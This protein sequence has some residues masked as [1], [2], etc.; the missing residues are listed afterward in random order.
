MA[1]L[2]NDLTQF[3]R[4]LTRV[5]TTTYYKQTTF[6]L[7]REQSE[8]YS[9]LMT[10]LVAAV[11]LAHDPSTGLPAE[12]MAEL[13]ARAQVAWNKVVGLM[14][15]FDL[16]PNRVLDVILDI[17]ANHV[18]N[19]YS[20][21]LE[22]LRLSSWAPS[23]IE[24][25]YDKS[26][27]VVSAGSY[28]GMKF[29]DVLMIAELG[30][31]VPD[32]PRPTSSSVLAQILGFKY[33]QNV[34]MD[35]SRL[36]TLKLHAVAALLIREG[37]IHLEELYPHLSPLDEEMGKAEEQYQQNMKQKA[38]AAQ[39]S[40]GPSMGDSPLK[41]S[42]ASSRSRTS[43]SLDGAK[44]G[45]PN[46]PK[47][48]P[49]QKYRLL[50]FLLCL[51]ALRPA[52]YL[53]AQFPWLPCAH[54]ELSDI[55]LYMV[56]WSI[57][58]LHQPFSKAAERITAKNHPITDR[59]I[60]ENGSPPKII[61]K[62]KAL[63]STYPVPQ[64]NQYT[65]FVFFYPASQNHIP[66]CSNVRELFTVA[67]PLLRYVKVN[68]CR[69]IGLLTH[70]CRIG[71]ADLIEG[72]SFGDD[73]F[74]SRLSEWRGMLRLYIL[75]A[76]S[77]TRAN[78]AFNVEVWN[79][80]KFYDQ[81]ER[82][83]MYGE[84][85][86][87]HA[88]YPEVK[89]RHVEV[90]R[91]VRS[92]LRRVTA[93]ST[94][95]LSLPLAK[96]AHSNPCLVFAESVRQSMAYDN[97]IE[98]I[99]ESARS[100]TYLGYDVLVYS[101]L[102]AFTNS[103][104]PRMKEDGTSVAM[105]LQSLSTYTATL[106]KKF[107]GSMDS[108][109]ILQLLAHRLK[110][111][112]SADLIILKELIAKTTQIQPQANLTDDQ[113]AC[114]GGGSTLHPNKNGI[115][116]LSGALQRTDLTVALLVLIAQQREF[117]IETVDKS[118]EHL[119]HISNLYDECQAILFQYVEFL[120]SAY[121]TDYASLLP[122]LHELC[123]TYKLQPDI[124]FHIWRPALHDP[125]LTHNI[126][127]IRA[128]EEKRIQKA[129]EDSE[130]AERRLKQELA[131]KR[132]QSQATAS[133]SPSASPLP[134]EGME[135][136]S[137]DSKQENMPPFESVTS[138]EVD[139]PT[140]K[141][142]SNATLGLS[143]NGNVD[144][145][146]TWLPQLVPIMESAERVLPASA[147]RVFSPGLYVTFWQMSMYDLVPLQKP[148]EREVSKINSYLKSMPS[149]DRD[150]RTEEHMQATRKALLEEFTEQI[151]N[152]QA[153]QERLNREKN[154]WFNPDATAQEAVRHFTQHC[155]H[156][157]SLLSPTDAEF[158]ARFLKQLHL[159][160]TPR[161]SSLSAYNNA[162]DLF[163]QHL[164]NQIFCL[165]EHEIYNF[166]RF[167]RIVL[168][169]LDAFSTDE[170]SFKGG[171][172]NLQARAL[173][174]FAKKFSPAEEVTYA[175]LI[176]IAEFTGLVGKFIMRLRKSIIQLLS[177]DTY[178]GVRNAVI[179]LNGISSVFPKTTSQGNAIKAVI[180][181]LVGSEK[182]PDLQVLLKSYNTLLQT[183]KSSW[184]SDVAGNGN[185]NAE[186]PP[187]RSASPV[188]ANL[189]S[190]PADVIM[191][192]P[193]SLSNALVAQAT[194]PK[195]PI[196]SI[197]RPAVVRRVRG[198]AASSEISR[199][200]T[201]ESLPAKPSAM[202]QEGLKPA[203]SASLPKT[204]QVVV[205]PP[206]R[207]R[208]DSANPIPGLPPRPQSQED[209]NARKQD[210]PPPVAPSSTSAAQ[211]IRVNT[212]HPADPILDTAPPRPLTSD[213]VK[214]KELS[215][216]RPRTPTEPS[217][218]RRQSPSSNSR[219]RAPSVESHSSARDDRP[220]ADRDRDRERSDR[221][222]GGSKDE[223]K[224][225]PRVGRLE[226]D[227]RSRDR[228]GR[229]R[230]RDRDAHRD[231]DSGRDRGTREKDI[232]DARDRDR[233][234]REKE[235][236]KRDRDRERDRDNKDSDR[237][238]DRPRDKDRSSRRDGAPEPGPRRMM[239]ANGAGGAILS[240]SSRRDSKNE[241]LTDRER[242][243]DDS[244]H[245]R[246][247]GDEDDSQSAKRIRGSD[248]SR[249]AASE[250]DRDRDRENG[251]DRYRDD[252][253]RR[254][255]DTRDTRD[256]NRRD[257]TRRS[258]KDREEGGSTPPKKISEDNMTSGPPPT[259]PRANRT[260]D[261]P[262]DIG[263]TTR[264]P[265]SSG[266]RQ[267]ATS[268][269]LAD[270]LSVAPNDSSA[271]KDDGKG[272]SPAEGNS[273]ANGAEAA[274]DVAQPPDYTPSSRS[275]VPRGDSAGPSNNKKRTSSHIS[276][277]HEATAGAK[278]FAAANAAAGSGSGSNGGGAT[279]RVKIDRTRRSGPK[280]D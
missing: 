2:V 134:G 31:N 183:R 125:I 269:R 59:I 188:T 243:G 148:T 255:R 93:N 144:E 171:G 193:P 182:R 89:V 201:P 175:E 122:S 64:S 222:R 221:D 9:K 49:N 245:K 163:G 140:T 146:P 101:V 95:K 216:P 219:S 47:E 90:T 251:R 8:G 20:F 119:K 208:P 147:L 69:D 73:A 30:P 235:D 256:D 56:R 261:S 66:V 170:K 116:R 244:S 124:A 279:K 237:E 15:V 164:A 200:G 121:G 123:T 190:R 113:V 94:N 136:I 206:A 75:P 156:P 32:P 33:V 107:G 131:A 62:K 241:D 223:I 57:A 217:K 239:D 112:R 176:T 234:G 202:L 247:R 198:E 61:P 6:N 40:G 63:T 262:R 272:K 78:A 3:E 266:T 22:L 133:P 102:T 132:A 45:S 1:G 240:R 28:E 169:D 128:F 212:G 108:G 4:K 185:S 58:P 275:P 70:I 181:P 186:P 194:D 210:M 215:T 265:S 268:S 18:L 172:K 127:F 91:E 72:K 130:A 230:D 195:D 259:A 258:R 154:H 155:L 280:M 103:A 11:G 16:N 139:S 143:N 109:P 179:F 273:A 161:F 48:P 98:A 191:L 82:W 254:D 242:R 129:K 80:L 138:M 204:P 196:A 257:S 42:A 159:I 250:K 189:P 184:I 60:V 248:G 51:G 233:R 249:Y 226:D 135:I 77:M 106:Y 173:P 180:E 104:K 271:P 14:G 214:D 88:L 137:K 151:D 197:P 228:S 141:Q 111:F 264:A 87:S 174:G 41:S 192:E 35:A 85:A 92:I 231:R 96:L 232:R 24:S 270:R 39:S 276:A 68:A 238:W 267:L 142:E 162:S 253:S 46:I 81:T 274:K 105:W 99:A 27:T 21:F 54:T 263:D 205:S 71:K 7:L 167:Y 114:M 25:Q 278:L 203:P 149:R 38:I 207:R 225:R 12:S 36:D 213:L 227:D 153:T 152:R 43:A 65:E 83:G 55:I 53:L 19:H 177:S 168:E 34:T 158:S 115:R 252:R 76:L 26:A 246:R 209:V 117:C 86:Q 84:W 52:I 165:S 187:P 224:D 126:T 100:L 236:G 74:R 37:F 67:E 23:S 166:S 44:S 10:E 13:R 79:V 97:L 150:R 160:G 50:R 120:I 17:F 5:R 199:A 260:R 211:N 110:N 118:E 277:A 29:E 218:D 157:R 229:D 145:V 178:V 220:K